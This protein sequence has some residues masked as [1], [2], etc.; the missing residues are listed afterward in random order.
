MNYPEID[1]EIYKEIERFKEYEYT[2]CIA[3]EM[4][5]RNK[6]IKK[7]I[8]QIS[9]IPVYEYSPYQDEYD[10]LDKE[11][12]ERYFIDWCIRKHLEKTFDNYVEEKYTKYHDCTMKVKYLSVFEG[13]E[14]K[15]IISDESLIN[16]RSHGEIIHDSYYNN[17]ER[18]KISFDDILYESKKVHLNSKPLGHKMIPDGLGGIKE[19]KE[20]AKA[21]I[22]DRN[23][24]R[25]ERPRLQIP[26]E[27]TKEIVLKIN[28]ALPVEEL[29]S[30]LSK[31]KNDYDK[32]TLVIKSPLEL[33]GEEL[34]KADE[35]K[36]KAIPKEKEKRK[37]AMANAFYVYDMYKILEPKYL[38]KI[39]SFKKER[40]SKVRELKQSK[41]YDR[42]EKNSMIKDIKEEYIFLLDQYSKTSIKTEIN[43]QSGLS[44]D[45]IERYR[46]L[47]N[48]YIDNLKYK[49]LITGISN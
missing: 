5:I 35:I 49:E 6:E 20:E 28:L 26:I 23:Y 33:V 10:K 25:F 30:Y 41:N 34:D 38:T 31:I 29:V 39:N 40:D 1:D 22:E 14:L 45:D 16:L 13:K 15:E 9:K 21:I 44:I 7:L 46:A 19:E 37:K 12:E 42:Q 24:L 4:A 36:S 18:Y 48:K 43:L 32:D 47:M 3:Y 17:I 2:N 11:L 8:N 27:S